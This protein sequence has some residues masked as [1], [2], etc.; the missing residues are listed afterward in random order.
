MNDG[1]RLYDT[2]THIG[3]AHHSG[4]TCTALQMLAVMDRTGVDR[5]LLIPFPVVEDFRQQHDLIADAVRQHPDR[6]AGSACLPPFIPRP[7]FQDEVKRK[8]RKG[9]LLYNSLAVIFFHIEIL[10]LQNQCSCPYSH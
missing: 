4:R 6:F 2:H 5:A 10:F 9:F 7:E 3:T 8:P 1:F